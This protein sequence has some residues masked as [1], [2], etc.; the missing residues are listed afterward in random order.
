MVEVKYKSV[1][2]MPFL[3]ITI[4]FAFGICGCAY[5]GNA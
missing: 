5:L 3:L 4:F 2:E 1:F